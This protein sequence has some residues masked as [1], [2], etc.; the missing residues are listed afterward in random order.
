[1]KSTVEACEC[2][3]CFLAIHEDI[4]HWSPDAEEVKE[5]TAIV[6]ILTPIVKAGISDAG[7]W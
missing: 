1:M 4:M 3:P 6:E 2:S 7:G 5:A